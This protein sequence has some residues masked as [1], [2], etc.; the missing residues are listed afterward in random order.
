M[1]SQVLPTLEHNGLASTLLRSRRSSDSYTPGSSAAGGSGGGDGAG[2]GA[3]REPGSPAPLA[4]LSPPGPGQ[5][6][7]AVQRHASPE[8]TLQILHGKVG[9]AGAGGWLGEGQG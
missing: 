4:P 8:L 2:A 7:E 5:L 3:S 6:E 1:L 9:S